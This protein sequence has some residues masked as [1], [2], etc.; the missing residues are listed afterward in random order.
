MYNEIFGHVLSRLNPSLIWISNELEYFDENSWSS[1][2]IC[3]K[4]FLNF[5]VDDI[6]TIYLQGDFHKDLVC[7]F[8]TTTNVVAVG[9]M[10]VKDKQRPPFYFVV[11]LMLS[12]GVV[13][14]SRDP[15]IFMRYIAK[16][17]KDGCHCISLS[18]ISSRK[19]RV[20][21]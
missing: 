15:Y 1:N 14:V 18:K 8:L 6:D 12:F 19:M 11:Y 5:V 10:P 21:L 3:D 13:Y 17:L 9:R 7:L 4:T 20:L 16:D 2:E